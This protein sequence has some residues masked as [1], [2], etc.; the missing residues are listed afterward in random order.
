MG[1]KTPT[2]Q[3]PQIHPLPPL[4]RVTSGIH[5]LDI[6][7]R[8]GFFRGGVYILMGEPGTGKTIM[9]NQLAYHHVHQGGRV[10][11]LTLLAESHARMLAHI[12]S[13]EFFDPEPIGQE[14]YYISGYTVL[15]QQ[16]LDG[17]LKLVQRSVRERKASLL[18]VDGVVNALS[19]ASE[20][21]FAQ[22]IHQMQQYVQASN[23]TSF[24]LSSI[25]S[26]DPVAGH[27]AVDGLLE[28]SRKR[29]GLR[30]VREIE[31]LKFRGSD[32]IDGGN[33]IRVT[34]HGLLLY[35]RTEAL[36]SS[37]PEN[38][39]EKR[40]RVPF[41]VRGLD[42]MLNG[43]LLSSSSTLLI[44]PPGSGKTSLGLHFLAQ[45]AH[46]GETCVYFG[47]YETTPRLIEKANRL[48]LD[49]T[50]Y[51]HDRTIL[52]CWQPPLEGSLDV[53]AERLLNAIPGSRPTRVFLDGINALSSVSVYPERAGTFIASLTNELRAREATTLFA[54]ETE[55]LLGVPSA[56]PFQG[57][58]A[59]VDNII[60]LRMVELRSRFF[61]LISI[62]KMRESDYDT[63]VREFKISACGVEVAHTFESAEEILKGVPQPEQAT[64]SAPRHTTSNTTGA[65]QQ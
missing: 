1:T 61:R 6:V 59:I 16:G 56:A 43:G 22:F 38:P 65:K 40:L 63:R 52:L 37:P 31:V 19:A 33:T 14:L 64:T 23:C 58:S 48:G 15:Q 62:L 41:G 34:N 3:R 39:H 44:G 29:V 11:Y 12:G 35:P 4:E 10:V 57:T 8:G 45:G 36:F 53:L 2:H 50:P 9:G 28:L 24:L 32:F 55:Q 27:T 30:V 26:N 5:G 46:N 20:I 60:A 51:I 21:A 47:F 13:M 54:A 42:D 17:L 25:T 7:L 49:F 18:I